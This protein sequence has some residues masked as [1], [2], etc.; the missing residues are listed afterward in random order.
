MRVRSVPNT[1]CHHDI[2]GIYR[3]SRGHYRVGFWEQGVQTSACGR[4]R[5]WLL[6]L[7]VFSVRCKEDHS[8]DWV[9]RG[10]GT[11]RM[12]GPGSCGGALRGGHKPRGH[13]KRHRYADCL[14]PR[15]KQ[16]S[17]PCPPCDSAG[18]GGQLS[19]HTGL[20][21]QTG[22]ACPCSHQRSSKMVGVIVPNSLRHSVLHGI[23]Y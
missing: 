18:G 7:Q 22:S 19:P 15:C 14:V 21:S 6:V 2:P 5:L 1:P 4:R 17:L 8:G 9:V 16:S 3:M 20:I 13:R 23:P 12:V 11:G 10:C